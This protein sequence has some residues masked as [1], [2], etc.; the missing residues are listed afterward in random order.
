MRIV[1]E[2]EIWAAYR[3][4]SLRELRLQRFGNKEAWKR[5]L[6]SPRARCVISFTVTQND[7][8]ALFR[9]KKVVQ[10]T[11]KEK[12]VLM[13]TKV[14]LSLT[15]LAILITLSRP[16]SNTKLEGKVWQYLKKNSSLFLSFFPHFLTNRKIRQKISQTILFE[17]SSFH[18]SKFSFIQ[19]RL[20]AH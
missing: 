17:L 13:A 8:F 7:R 15:V 14:V 18:W 11:W 20:N 2:S 9:G 5:S 12:G 19:C 16:S 10:S 6:M 4:F 3:F 1:F